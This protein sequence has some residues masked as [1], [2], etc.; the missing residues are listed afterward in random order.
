MTQRWTRRELLAMGVAASVA[1]VVGVACADGDAEQATNGDASTGEPDDAPTTSAGPVA[2]DLPP[3]EP[4]ADFPEGVM[5]GDPTAD[6]VVLWTRPSPELVATGAD[7]V[8]EVATDVEFATV[9]A[10]AS[11]VPDPDVEGATHFDVDGLDPATSYVYRFR[12][13]EAT[14]P[15]GLTRTAPA[16]GAPVTQLTMAVFSCQRWTHGYYT[17]HADLARQAPDLVIC[18]GDYVYETAEADGVD[19]P[20]RNDP[21]D[22]AT[23]L[24]EFRRKYE[25][26]RSDVNLQE[27]HRVSPL[28]AIP[29]N[30]DGSHRA[31]DR[32]YPGAHEAF[33]EK[34]PVRRDPSDPLATH[35]H[36]EWGNLV[37]L[38]M[39]DLYRW[40]SEGD[41]GSGDTNND[42]EMMDPQVTYLGDEQRQWLFDG[43]ADSH[44]TWQVLG[45]SLQFSPL[46]LAAHDDPAVLNA[47]HYANMKQW[48]GYQAERLA[49]LDEVERLGLTG[50]V[51]VSGYMHWFW[52]ADVPRDLDDPDSPP[53]MVD[54]LCG[55]I[56]SSNADEQLGTDEPQTANLMRA[57]GPANENY[58]RYFDGDRHGYGLLTFRP[59]GAEVEYRSPLTI[60]APTSDVEVL[61]TFRLDP[62]R[63]G[64]ERTSPTGWPESVLGPS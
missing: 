15:I 14:S 52:A 13:G 22:D 25:H 46:R 19:I 37:D 21:I 35:R 38:W 39:L 50:V 41:R 9:V 24:D 57:F 47:G 33:F 48:D 60:R 4:S 29:D 11:A 43:L 44:T 28:V 31:T 2:A 40:R 55:G 59:D 12:M 62:S 1:G 53:I 20:T 18:L 54:F 3:Y 34:M 58:V 64:I 30:H 45:S 56:S 5:S 49:V 7:L 63:A 36:L 23:T 16:P 17:A 51:A 27:V 8:A 61:A 10:T 26:Y 32:K 42:T 6:G